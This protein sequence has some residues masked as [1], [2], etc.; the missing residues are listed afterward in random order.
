MARAVRPFVVLCTLPSLCCLACSFLGSISAPAI[1]CRSA[2]TT[3]TARHWIQARSK[4]LGPIEPTFRTGDLNPN[5]QQGMNR[6]ACLSSAPEKCRCWRSS[7]LLLLHC[8]ASPPFHAHP[9]CT[10][11]TCRVRL[12]A[13][14][15]DITSGITEVQVMTSRWMRIVV[16]RFP[17]FRDHGLLLGS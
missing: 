5:G 6:R 14:P 1:C 8:A 10:T 2:R 3:G 16:L 13:A 17:L 9:S 11:T 4:S 7:D 15:F 12:C